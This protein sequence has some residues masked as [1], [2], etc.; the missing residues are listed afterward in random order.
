[1]LAATG[2]VGGG[3]S[4]GRDRAS[5]ASP[6]K[7]AAAAPEVQPSFSGVTAAEPTI[8][9]IGGRTLVIPLRGPGGSGQPGPST[10]AWRPASP[11]RVVSAADGRALS[12]ELRF[13]RAEVA[14][15][16]TGPR[17]LPA[18]PRWSTEPWN[19]SAAGE[20]AGGSGFWA[21]V[22]EVPP[23][24][25]GRSMRMDGASL[26]VVWSEPP[27]SAT[28]AARAPRLDAPPEAVWALGNAIRPLTTDPFNRWRGRVIEERFSAA[29][30][31]GLD[32]PGAIPDAAL[33]SMARQ[34]EDR[35]RAAI[36]RVRR[37]N[38]DLA[39]QVA[40][41]LTAVI[42]SPDGALLPA[43][44]T[45]E[46][47]EG[48]LRQRLL[49][50]AV[51]ESAALESV[52]H[53]LDE[54]APAVWVIDEST[55]GPMLNI[56]G[57]D[58]RPKAVA[59]RLAV[60]GIAERNGTTR[61]ASAA[62]ADVAARN[63]TQLR[64]HHSETLTFEF[65]V[66]SLPSTAGMVRADGWSK[67][68]VLLAAALACPPPGLVAGPMWPQWA[69]PTWLVGRSEAPLAQEAAIVL[70]QRT[71]KGAGW[72]A[73][74][75]CR[76][77]GAPEPEDMVRLWFGPF[78]APAGTIEARVRDGGAKSVR[79]MEDRWSALVPIPGGFLPP[80]GQLRVGFERVTGDGRRFSW[81]RPLMPAQKEPAR[82]VVDL[83]SWGSLAAPSE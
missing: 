75:E 36:D 20:A 67:P 77:I 68:V 23:T 5:A 53:W 47:S 44:N 37:A 76:T 35:W 9:A 10:S 22:V 63:A 52:R 19:S 13:F 61:V 15:A 21:V 24:A 51:A 1:M 12:T 26:P 38:P 2:L 42:L 8:V 30:L 32:R 41:T 73:Y 11:P 65:A 6:A 46:R 45:D 79:I 7:P 82:A 25:K 48:A 81:P 17:W 28:D 71:S 18:P 57:A 55:P 14:P 39:A 66:D 54:S 56:T 50:P 49:D 27:P 34:V 40:A 59:S 29:A 72:E 78:G 16:V 74:I 3:C 60:I 58:G 70:L 62:S 31:W 33:E 43:W 80:D 64:P 83:R 4:S 69:Q